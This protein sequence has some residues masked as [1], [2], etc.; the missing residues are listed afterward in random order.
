M[1]YNDKYKGYKESMKGMVYFN[2]TGT[3]AIINSYNVSSVTDENTGQYR[4]NF[5]TSP[6]AHAS[7]DHGNASYCVAMG[8]RHTANNTPIGYTGHSGNLME[9]PTVYIRNTSNNGVDSTGVTLV[10]FGAD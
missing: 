7:G 5:A 3:L 10:F 8:F 6:R 4:V 9:N 2:G 1:A